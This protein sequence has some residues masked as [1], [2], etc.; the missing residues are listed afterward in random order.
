MYI[1]FIFNNSSSSHTQKSSPIITA[2]SPAAGN[3]T[4]ST[5]EPTSDVV[6]EWATAQVTNEP[7]GSS[8]LAT[9]SPTNYN[10]VSISI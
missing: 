8:Y 10:N 7:T 9:L 6:N 2:E 5:N 1:Y 3:E 4:S